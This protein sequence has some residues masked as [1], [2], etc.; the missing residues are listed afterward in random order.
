MCLTCG[1]G[2][3][4]QSHG[5]KDNLRLPRL[6]RAAGAAGLPLMEA[7][8]NIPRTLLAAQL[9]SWPPQEPPLAEHPALVFDVDGILAFTAEALC[10][11]LNA[12]FDTAYSPLGQTFFPGTFVASKLPA[13]QAGWLAEHMNKPGFVSACAPDFHAMDVLR[14]AWHAGYTVCVVTERPPDLEEATAQWLED[15]GAPAVPVH[16]VGHGNKPAYLADRYGPGKPAVLIDDNPLAQ[17]TVARDGIEV[18]TPDR[19]YIPKIPRAH[20]RRFEGWPD[21]RWWL[22]L[23]QLPK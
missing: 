9:P 12:R 18:W 23:G 13:V 8:W 14:D 2:I 11:A 6:Q 15:W 3:V 22:K 17:I 19:Y 20:V 16:A 10:T 1:C 4:D 7:A 5:E 21:V